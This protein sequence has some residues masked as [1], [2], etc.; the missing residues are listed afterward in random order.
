M[1]RAR[2]GDPEAFAAFYRAYD[3]RLLRYLARRVFDADIA[4]DL[5]SETFALALEQRRQFRGQTTQEEQGW[6]FAIARGVLARY[7]QRAKLERAA[8]QRVGLAD[9][10]LEPWEHDHIEA[11]T[12]LDDL[13]G[14]LS[15]ALAQLS[16]D[17]RAAVELRVVHEA[18]YPEVARRLEVSEDVARARVSRGLRVLGRFLAP[19]DQIEESG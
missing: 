1:A 13:S 8:M 7:Y 14:E 10:Y 9:P 4:L 12:G 2:E 6:L 3:E 5:T 19:V 15:H 18:S 16:S 11:M 17:Q